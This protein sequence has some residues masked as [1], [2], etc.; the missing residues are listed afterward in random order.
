MVRKFRFGKLKKASF[1]SFYK[2]KLFLGSFMMINLIETY[3]NYIY[4]F[5][6]YIELERKL[7]FSLQTTNTPLD[8]NAKQIELTIRSLLAFYRVKIKKMLFRL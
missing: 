4:E 2:S 3:W 8:A 1:F 7:K 5:T 6:C